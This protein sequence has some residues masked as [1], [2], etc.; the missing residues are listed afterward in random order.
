MI[1]R[2]GSARTT[3]LQLLR[4]GLTPAEAANIAAVAEG[5]RPA[6]SGWTVREIE[7]L[8]FLRYMQRSGRIV[9]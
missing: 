9:P 6:A 2:T 8:R 3:Q 1:S 5:L 7:L 4:S